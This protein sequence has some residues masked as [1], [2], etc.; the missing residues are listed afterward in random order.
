MIN[1]VRFPEA[2]D[3]PLEKESQKRFKYR[4]IKP[5][6]SE[7]S[8]EKHPYVMFDLFPKDLVI[9]FNSGVNIIVGENGSGKSTLIS[10]IKGYVG[11]SPSELQLSFSNFKTEEEYIAGYQN[12]YKGYIRVDGNVTYKNAIFFNGEK[13][14][15]IIAIPKMINPNSSDY[16]SLTAQLFFANEESHGESMLPA[17]DY[18]LDTA[19]GGYVIF[20]DEPETALSLGNQIRLATKLKKSAEYGNQLIVCTHSLAVINEFNTLFDME[21][22]QLVD[23]VKY[24]DEIT[25]FGKPTYEIKKNRKKS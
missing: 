1:S 22:R 2:Y 4:T 14:N 13:D 6:K 8:R 15:P 19:K 11:D 9:E 7:Y 3:L 16:V 20:M 24:V 21:T 25:T 23:R 17:L 10:L 12:D 5:S 18:I